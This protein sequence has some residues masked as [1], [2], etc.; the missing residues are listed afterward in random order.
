[1]DRGVASRVQTAVLDN[2]P[3]VVPSNLRDPAVPDL[4]FDDEGGEERVTMLDEGEEQDALIP[5]SAAE[6]RRGGG[7]TDRP[8]LERSGSDPAAI[9][10]PELPTGATPEAAPG[11]GASDVEVELS[12]LELT[13]LDTSDLDVVMEPLDDGDSLF[14]SSGNDLSETEPESRD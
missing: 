7:S 3:D 10:Q 14:D 2:E 12:E 6:L 5:L 1:M 9:T 13:E 8:V 4:E 11:T